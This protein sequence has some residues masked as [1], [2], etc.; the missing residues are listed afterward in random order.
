MSFLK[1]HWQFT[2]A[3]VVVL[4]VLLLGA[5]ALYR[6]SEPS[7]P[8]TIYGVPERSAP[9]NSPALNTGGIVTVETVP[10]ANTRGE[11][12]PQ[13]TELASDSANLE[14]CCP[15]EEL[16]PKPASAHDATGNFHIHSPTPEAIED[17]RKHREFIRSLLAHGEE[18]QA[19]VNEWL[20]FNDEEEQADKI[21]HNGELIVL[22]R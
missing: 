10:N 2:V 15:D 16:F 11:T 13:E 22:F 21:V 4:C 18:A 5:V 6:A 19:L 1:N 14:S 7:E 9:N 3:A 20:S 17:A 12:E 8:K